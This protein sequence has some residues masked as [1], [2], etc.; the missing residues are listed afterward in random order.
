MYRLCIVRYELERSYEAQNFQWITQLNNEPVGSPSYIK[1]NRPTSIFM[2]HKFRALFQS[3][4]KILLIHLLMVI[5]V[6]V[7]QTSIATNTNSYLSGQW[8]VVIVCPIIMIIIK[9]IES[10]FPKH[11]DKTYILRE[12]KMQTIVSI[13]AYLMYLSSFVVWINSDFD[14]ILLIIINAIILITWTSLMCY[15]ETDYILKQFN[16]DKN[17]NDNDYHNRNHYK[18]NIDEFW[19]CM[20]DLTTF[21]GFMRHSEMVFALEQPL[22]LVE[23][24]YYIDK[25][26][27]TE[28]NHHEILPILNSYIDCE[29]MKFVPKAI[30][31]LIIDYYIKLYPKPLNLIPLFPFL[32][33]PGFK[34]ES[35]HWNYIIH[36]YLDG[37]SNWQ[38]PM[39]W[40]YVR[41]CNNL[42][43]TNQMDGECWRLMKEMHDWM[44]LMVMDSFCRFMISPLS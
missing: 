16:K 14:W 15:F 18:L 24:A 20:L 35:D 19:Q 25:W 40:K 38:A 44:K 28:Y 11:K 13:I 29:S 43:P 21:E 6:V 8:V 39:P 41:K 9:W 2:K 3:K 34:H 27:S 4:W 36:K 30:K 33:Q 17:N 31:A 10:S 26:A 23:V 1:I 7:T 37:N 12:I 42:D 32:E 22:F 5:L